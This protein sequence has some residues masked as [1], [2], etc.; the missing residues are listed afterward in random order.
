MKGA[1]NCRDSAKLQS[2]LKAQK[3][4][5]RWIAAIC[6]SPALVLEHHG[7]LKGVKSCCYPCFTEK[8]SCPGPVGCRV[9][10][11]QNISES[12]QRRP[13]SCAARPSEPLAHSL[14]FFGIRLCASRLS[15]IHRPRQRVRVC[16]RNS[17]VSRRRGQKGGVEET[18]VH[19]LNPAP[20]HCSGASIWRRRARALR[21]RRCRN[22]F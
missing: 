14:F 2:M 16:A 3:E 21:R 8:L 15:H 9:C 10:V 5:G 7:L 20:S 11:D 17:R 13:L 22:V 18:D 1:E 19:G 6:A 12:P 4:A